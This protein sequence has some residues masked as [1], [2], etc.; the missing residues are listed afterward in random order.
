M[1]LAA[2]YNR[3]SLVQYLVMK[4]ADVFAVRSRRKEGQ[5]DTPRDLAS[6]KGHAAV[7]FYLDSLQVL[8]LSRVGTNREEEEHL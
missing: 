6:R 1:H 5:A 4:G 2:S 3:L 8:L 7:V